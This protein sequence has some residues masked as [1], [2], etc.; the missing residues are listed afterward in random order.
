MNRTKKS[1]TSQLSSYTVLICGFGSQSINNESEPDVKTTESQIR[2]VVVVSDK[3]RPHDKEPSDNSLNQSVPVDTKRFSS[4]PIENVMS[5]CM[6]KFVM[7]EE[8]FNSF[9]TPPREVIIPRTGIVISFINR[10]V[11]I[12]HTL[13]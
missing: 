12:T 10:T 13:C 2:Y 1:T 6:K 4:S 7:N 3:S 5:K 8:L 9:E 11:I